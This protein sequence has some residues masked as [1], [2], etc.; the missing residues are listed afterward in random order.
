[1]KSRI[2]HT[3]RV[4]NHRTDAGHNGNGNHNG[5]SSK[6]ERDTTVEDALKPKFM[7]AAKSF[8]TAGRTLAEIAQECIDADVSR[9]TLCAWLIECGYAESSA[10]S[11]LSRLLV[12]QAAPGTK[13]AKGGRA[14]GA[15]RK[16]RTPG[17]LAYN[18]FVAFLEK[19]DVAKLPDDFWRDVAFLAG[20]MQAGES[21]PKPEVVT[22]KA[23]QRAI[24]PEAI[25]KTGKAA[26]PVDRVAL[27]KAADARITA[28][29]KAA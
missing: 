20:K 24:V 25:A 26:K 27:L 1:M 19:L 4:K 16:S 7:A 2:A 13:S 9:T 3:N 15:G 6:A 17:V 12:S 29:P 8:G 21:L 14:K 10:R 18:A 22:S 28:L 11:T 23:A 5:N